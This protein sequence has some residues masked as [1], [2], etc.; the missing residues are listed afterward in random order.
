MLPNIEAIIT[1]SEQ[2]MLQVHLNTLTQFHEI[3]KAIEEA[4]R[5]KERAKLD[6]TPPLE[7]L[8]LPEP[9]PSTTNYWIIGLS[10]STLLLTSLYCYH[11]G[12]TIRRLYREYWIRGRMGLTLTLDPDYEEM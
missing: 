2:D 4:T 1:P 12:G 8:R 7:N 3:D 10:I 6:G 9:T 5:N 11:Y